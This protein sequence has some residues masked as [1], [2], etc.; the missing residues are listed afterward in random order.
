MFD[1]QQQQRR[2]RRH[3]D[4]RNR[5]GVVQ[6]IVTVAVLA[7]GSYRLLKWAWES[8]G[9]EE[10]ATSENG[11]E[12]N[13]DDD[14]VG[15]RNNVSTS[16]GVASESTGTENSPNSRLHVQK[17]RRNLHRIRMQRIVACKGNTRTTFGQL[18]EA[19]RSC[20]EG[21]TD[22]SDSTDALKRHRKACRELGEQRKSVAD[23]QLE[24]QLWATIQREI[25]TRIVSTLYVHTLVFIVLTVQVH[26]MGGDSFR[27]SLGA[28]DDDPP[29]TAEQDG[30]TSAC[31]ADLLSMHRQFM[32]QGIPE[33]T[34]LVR[35]DVRNVLTDAPAWDILDAQRSLQMNFDAVCS[36]IQ[37][38]RMRVEKRDYKQAGGGIERF[39]FLFKPNSSHDNNIRCPES[40]DS[41]TSNTFMDESWDVLESPLVKD[42][43]VGSF[44]TMFT[45]LCET[46]L[47]YIFLKDGELN[48][49]SLVHVVA[50]LQQ[51]TKSLYSFAD[52]TDE[53]NPY[54]FLL[55]DQ[56]YIKEMSDAS[57]C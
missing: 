30:L 20:I 9:T 22:F 14:V 47:R 8:W 38:I 45:S 10:D 31:A 43:I 16:T 32:Q 42:A 12:R 49:Q 57:F 51:T 35:N 18:Q 29:S 52:N 41:S 1:P 26:V 5:P 37:Q 25:F 46:K 53:P 44:N 54:V 24:A 40:H 2:R 17:Q 23:R 56:P 4:T 11:K 6:S 28:G 39:L 34:S 7:Y 13:N 55:D 36:T 33:L 19:L 50:Q 3:G 15:E 27:K 48:N 21:N